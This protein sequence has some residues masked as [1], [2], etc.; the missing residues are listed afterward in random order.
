MTALHRT[1]QSTVGHTWLFLSLQVAGGSTGSLKEAAVEAR[2][3][4]E[5]AACQALG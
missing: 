1:L 2:E 5:R 4:S 3:E